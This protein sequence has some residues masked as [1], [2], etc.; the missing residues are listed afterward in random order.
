MDSATALDALP[1]FAGARA[2]LES[3]AKRAVGLHA[4][5]IL[6]W[7][8]GLAVLLELAQTGLLLAIGD[9]YGPATI[10]RDSVTKISWSVLVCLAL[11][12]GLAFTTGRPHQAAL[13]G[14]L[15]AP[16]ASLT[17]RALAVVAQQFTFAA[18]PAEA[19]PSLVVAV[20][21]GGE[22]ATLA[23][24]LAW[25]AKHS[26]SAPRHYALTGLASGLLFGGLLMALTLRFGSGPVTPPAV[27][28]WGVTELLF[29]VGCALIMFGAERRPAV[30][31]LREL[32]LGGG[33]P[34]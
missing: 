13:I 20:L 26:W 10:V 29:P 4:L 22:Y 7:S 2:R 3:D 25:L 24:G 31:V 9:A 6:A 15:V 28:A 1:R 23:L 18:A 33:R 27:V 5:H 8:L 11:W 17:A 14:L 21:K 19:L 30:S 32:A 12:A 16:A 34:A